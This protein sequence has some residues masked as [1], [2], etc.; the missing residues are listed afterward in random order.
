MSY[1]LGD[2]HGGETRRD[3]RVVGRDEFVDGRIGGSG[4]MPGSEISR[5]GIFSGGIIGRADATL[6]VLDDEKLLG[7]DECI[8]WFLRTDQDMAAAVA[9]T[10]IRCP[11]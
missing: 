3:S 6:P 11:P 7:R 2:W 9:Q 4:G 10:R 5:G 8:G 1:W